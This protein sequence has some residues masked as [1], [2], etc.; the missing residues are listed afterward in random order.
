MTVKGD[1][2]VE[3]LLTV[4]MTVFIGAVGFWAMGCMGD[5][6]DLLSRSDEETDEQISVPKRT[7]AAS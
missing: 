4:M 5:M 7:N 6:A 2:P 3:I 1:E